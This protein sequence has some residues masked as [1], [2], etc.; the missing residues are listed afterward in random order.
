MSLNEFLCK[1]FEVDKK[2]N[3]TIG[4]ILTKP[5]VLC[6]LYLI[7]IFFMYG[8]YI[9]ED[10]S[11]VNIIYMFFIALYYSTIIIIVLYIIYRILK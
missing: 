2:G 5:F 9:T 6:I 7:L 8:I 4:S 1:N 10:Y 11:I 3:I